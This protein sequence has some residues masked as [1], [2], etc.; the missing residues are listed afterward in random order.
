[1][2]NS[3]E[4]SPESAQKLI[5]MAEELMVT[6]K[7]LEHALSTNGDEDLSGAKVALKSVVLLSDQVN[8][9]IRQWLEREETL[10]ESPH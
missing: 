5:R 3:E 6:R 1:M 10:R 2:S 7:A 8:E 9:T 4:I